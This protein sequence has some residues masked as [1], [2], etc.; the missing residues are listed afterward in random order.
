[1]NSLFILLQS[2]KSFFRNCISIWIQ[3]PAPIKPKKWLILK[4]YFELCAKHILF[5]I[6]LGFKLKS[7]QIFDYTINF[8]S[9]IH[10]IHLFEES[11][12]RNE[13]Y[14]EP[15]SKSPTIFD[16]GGNIDTALYF[17][18][19][20]PTAKIITFEADPITFRLLKR[21]VEEN[22]LRDVKIYNYAVYDKNTRIKFYS[23]PTEPGSGLNSLYKSVY[24]M[25]KAINRPKTV[26]AKTLSPFIKGRVDLLKLD[27]EGAEDVVL[28]ELQKSKRLPLI[29]KIV[30]EYH[31]HHS[32]KPDD[33][34]KFLRILENNKFSYLLT[35]PLKAPFEQGIFQ[36]III[37]AYK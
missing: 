2:T 23:N 18:W 37:F 5:E 10:Y 28:A 14:F 19:L 1:M 32:E 21:N 15:D 31:H 33:L 3:L 6:I 25:R 9:L 34:S 16:C 30:T 4:T 35:T 11:Y 12:I 36:D 17:K 8:Y 22:N 26:E 29:K 13:Y 24:S 27:I 7:V 20:Y